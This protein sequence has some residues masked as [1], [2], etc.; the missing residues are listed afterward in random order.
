MASFK[1]IIENMIKMQKTPHYSWKSGT[2]PKG[3]QYCVKGEK[4]VL[5]VTGLCPRNCF[6]CPISEKKY[7]K[8]VIYA[9]EWPIKNEKEILEEA[10]LIGAKGAG[11]TG[12]DPLARLDRTVRYIKMLK[13]HFGRK[14]HTHL[15]TSLDLVDENKIKK[16]YSAGLDEIRIHPD[17]FSDKLWHKFGIITKYKWDM[18]IEIP[19]IP[20]TK[21]QTEKLIDFFRDKI[22][23][24]NINELE[25]ADNEA[26]RMG[27]KF[28]VKSKL[29]Y[30]VKGSEELAKYLLKKYQNKIKSIHYCTAKLK[31]KVQ[32]GTRIKRRAQNAR[33]AYDSVTKEG[34]LVRGAIY[35]DR[36]I[37]LKNYLTKKYKIPRELFEI[38]KG[39]KRLLTTTAVAER[40]KAEIK[41]KGFKPAIATEYPTWDKLPIE[42][43]F[44]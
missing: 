11:F 1:I 14:F 41:A 22:K 7:K 40:L 6:Y 43:Q 12:G 35:G 8:D 5:F 28:R 32:L 15:Y 42:I 16:L 29:S 25:V 34:L 23:F 36:L 26:Q 17:I 19:S 33:K 27:K 31:D 18:G 30:A 10:R 21:K 9:D 2:L 38:D 39:R 24:L 3:C 44:L 37:R 13:K 20:G 4:L